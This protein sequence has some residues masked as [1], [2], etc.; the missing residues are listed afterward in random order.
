MAQTARQ[1]S[2]TVGAS[3]VQACSKV[4]GGF[5]RTQLAVTNT[6]ATAVVTIC[7]GMVAAVAGAGIR[8]PPNGSYLESTDSAF[9][10]WQDEV[11]I[12]AD[13]AGTVAVV[14]RQKEI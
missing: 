12:V 14:E 3:S 8:L 9:E 7:F 2:V 1:S 10:C 4:Q 13:A 6:S 5:V 11:Q